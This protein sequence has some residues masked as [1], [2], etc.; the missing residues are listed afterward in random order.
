MK[1]D[2]K[3][4]D[5]DHRCNVRKGQIRSLEN[6]NSKTKEAAVSSEEGEKPNTVDD[7]ADVLVNTK[8]PTPSPVELSEGDSDQS[9][10]DNDNDADDEFSTEPHNNLMWINICRA[11]V[12]V[13]SDDVISKLTYGQSWDFDNVKFLLSAAR[14]HVHFY[15]V[16]QKLQKSKNAIL[17]KFRRIIEHT[18][19]LMD[20]KMEEVA[21]ENALYGNTIDLGNFTN[22]STAAPSKKWIWT[23]PQLKKLVN[24]RKKGRTFDEIAKVL[25]KTF[26]LCYHKFKKLSRKYP[27]LKNGF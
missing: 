22:A 16:M 21:C 2:I 24:M 11:G 23:K 5:G 25:D 9:Y 14:D 7:G 6:K 4:D 1:Y 26:E 12:R 15:D 20:R 17:I 13:P 10:S 19:D 18:P 27:K 3:F 8:A